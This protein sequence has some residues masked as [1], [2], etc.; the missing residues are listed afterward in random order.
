MEGDINVAGIVGSMAIEYD[1]DPE[2][3]LTKVG[4]KSLDFR[5]LARA[6]M[7]DCINRERSP[8]RSLLSEAEPQPAGQLR[9]FLS[10]YL[11][12][13]LKIL[14]AYAVWR[15]RAWRERI[16]ARLRPASRA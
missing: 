13:T 4:D 11:P 8:A 2:D 14:R 5:Y 12:T 3:D 15:S 1:F 6:V 9:S 16:S 10:Y 7:L